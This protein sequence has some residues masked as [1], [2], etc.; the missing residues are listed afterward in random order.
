MASM[1][2]LTP[3]DPAFQ[4]GFEDADTSVAAAVAFA[5]YYGRL[6]GPGSSP[7][8]HLGDAPPFLV[9]HGSNDS[10]SLVEDTRD[11]VDRL[12]IKST[13]PVVYAE[14]PGGQHAF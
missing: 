7:L 4:P 5:G 12:R 10:L 14:L 1:I 9:V 2:A 13:G 6:D 11:L 8:D 3:N